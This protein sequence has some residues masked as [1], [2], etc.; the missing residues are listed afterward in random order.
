MSFNLNRY[1]DRINLTL[2]VGSD[3]E[4]LAA[5]QLAQLTAIP[6]EN[7][8][9]LLGRLPDLSTQAIWRKAVLER[10]GGY[11]LEL[12]DLLGCALTALGFSYVS[13]L[14]RIRMGAAVGGPR[15]HLAHLV[16]ASGQTWLCD[17]GF[18]GPGSALPVA[19]DMRSPVTTPW[20]TFRLRDDAAT[21]ETVL[22]RET[23]T[24]WFALYGF[25][26]SPITQAEIAEANILCATGSGSPF[27]S[28]LMMNRLT[29]E[30]RVS[31][32]DREFTEMTATGTC[33]RSLTS[34]SELS[35]VLANRFGLPEALA[36]DQAI[37]QR[38]T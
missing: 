15:T 20:G 2:P 29:K 13:I 33:Q 5:L 16:E 38:I 34:A 30:G 36:R 31:L 14:G 11:C 26:R 8:E 10:R 28:H 24:G 1:L 27:P 19:L 23:P 17:A 25:D 18:G 12:N 6:F 37:W 7:T 32:F 21:G 9:P 22:E 3:R 35:D 4:Q